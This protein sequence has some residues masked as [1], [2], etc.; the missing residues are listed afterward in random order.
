MRTDVRTKPALDAVLEGGA[1][2]LPGAQPYLPPT[3]ILQGMRA[4]TRAKPA[5]EQLP[6]L[7]LGYSAT[8]R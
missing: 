7:D 5:K 3:H 2:R 8:G 1:L 4:G 6:S